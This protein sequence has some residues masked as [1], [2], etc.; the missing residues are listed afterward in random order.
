MITVLLSSI[1]GAFL[2]RWHGGGFGKPPK[3]LAGAVWSLPFAGVAYFATSQVWA[4]CAVFALTLLF[5]Q[6]GH[7][8]AMDAGRSVKEPTAGRT[9]ERLEYAILWLNGRIP[10]RV[11][12]AILNAVIGLFAVLSCAVAVSFAEPLAGALI[13]L[14]GLLGRPT[15]YEIGHTLYDAGS[16]N[17]MPHWADHGSAIGELLYGAFIYAA[18]AAAWVML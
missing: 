6:T 17:R 15:A 5:R 7:G 13:A 12:D 2:S 16:L 4:A 14:A 18:L 10:A 8:G 9:P 1:V 3:L 11:Y